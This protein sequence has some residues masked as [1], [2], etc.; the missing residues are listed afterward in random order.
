MKEELYCAHQSSK[1]F[2]NVVLLPATC[3]QTFEVMDVL[4]VRQFMCFRGTN[5]NICYVGRPI[6]GSRANV[7]SVDTGLTGSWQNIAKNFICGRGRYGEFPRKTRSRPPRGPQGLPE[8]WPP[9]VRMVFRPY[10]GPWKA[11]SSETLSARSSRRDASFG[12]G[13]G[14]LRGG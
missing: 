5:P 9:R 8:P 12:T 11:V 3:K 1:K 14:S 6:P 7:C 2:F 10:L 13:P 4:G